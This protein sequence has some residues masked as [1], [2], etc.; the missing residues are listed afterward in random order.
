MLIEQEYWNLD[1]FISKL[2]NDPTSILHHKYSVE[3]Y[4]PSA[5]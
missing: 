1:L 5:M 2:Y 4:I 3:W